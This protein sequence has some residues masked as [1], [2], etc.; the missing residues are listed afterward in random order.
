MKVT[1]ATFTLG[2]LG[3]A[4]IGCTGDDSN[5]A[6]EPDAIPSP[7]G[8][9]FTTGGFDDVPVFRGATPIQGPS[10]E[11]GTVAA[12]YETQTATAERALRFYEQNLPPLGWEEVDPVTESSPGV[13]RGDWVRDGRRLQVSAL[14]FDM[15]EPTGRVQFSLVLLPDEGDVPV[16]TDPVDG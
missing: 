11:D 5:V 8:T 13:W 6:S 10:T 4:L 15:D 12:T 1:V 3:L 2:A 9:A 7:A 14:P 16:S